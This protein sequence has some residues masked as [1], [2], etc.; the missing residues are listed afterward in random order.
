MLMDKRMKSV[1][2]LAAEFN[3]DQSISQI[4]TEMKSGLKSTLRQSKKSDQ[5]KDQF[6]SKIRKEASKLGFNFVQD[7]IVQATYEAHKVVS[8]C[9]DLYG[10]KLLKKMMEMLEENS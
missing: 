6:M 2:Q 3:P 10:E 5:Y 8:H 9:L 1:F 7:N 4:P